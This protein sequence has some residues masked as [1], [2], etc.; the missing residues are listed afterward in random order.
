MQTA[1]VINTNRDF[2][3]S[4]PRVY[5][6]AVP[7]VSGYCYFSLDIRSNK[8]SFLEEYVAE[9]Q[10]LLERTA[11]EFR[12]GVKIELTGKSDPL[13]E[14]DSGIQSEV[15]AAA[16]AL[17]ISSVS[18][19]SGA[20]HDTAILGAEKR[21]DGSPVPVGMVFIPCRGGKSHCAEEFTTY[22]A[23]A[24]GASVMA[25]ALARIAE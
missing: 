17:G 1:G 16:M 9:A 7:K 20:G 23:I 11:A 14:M 6:N 10:Q 18:M 21:Q 4:E 22:E 12:T 2:N 19:A 25:A 24:K 13:E 3:E 15:K 8:T 5:E